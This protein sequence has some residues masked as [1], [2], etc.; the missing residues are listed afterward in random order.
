MIGQR[1]STPVLFSKISTDYQQLIIKGFPS[2]YRAK[3]DNPSK[4]DNERLEQEIVDHFE[5]YE[6]TR[7]FNDRELVVLVGVYLATEL[8]P[9]KI[10]VKYP[11][12]FV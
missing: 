12:F 3:A 4:Y 2:E 11:E 9:S 8:R 1:F 7:M 10:A 5:V 6:E